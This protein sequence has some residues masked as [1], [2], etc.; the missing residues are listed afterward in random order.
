MKIRTQWVLSR[1]NELA[2]ICSR[3]RF[4]GRDSGHIIT[5]VKHVKVKPKRRNVIKFR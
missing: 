4:S 5:G 1:E 3:R 2:D